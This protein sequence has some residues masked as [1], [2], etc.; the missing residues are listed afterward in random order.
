MSRTVT[1]V[2][3]GCGNLGCVQNALRYLK[4]DPLI[5]P[6]SQLSNVDPTDSNI[7]FPGVGNFDY[8][9][10]SISSHTSVYFLRDWLLSSRRAMC[11]C[12]GF[13]LL[14]SSSAERMPPSLGDASAT[15]EG[16]SIFTSCVEPLGPNNSP[17]LNIGWR[18]S[19]QSMSYDIP[20]DSLFHL[21]SKSPYYHMHSYGLPLNQHCSSDL[22]SY[23]WY[24]TSTHLNSG[25]EFVS[26]F[27]G[28]I[29]GL[30]FHPEKVV[31][32]V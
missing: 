1:I 22:Q 24:V 7:L 13:Q 31:L 12:L 27:F 16:L 20:N 5:L 2:D 26:A 4:F 30:Q 23:D 15:N 21:A 11:I 29:L 19:S 28:N 6:I 8:A 18:R 14:Y 9:I 17:S 32:K 10:N 3:Y 25:V